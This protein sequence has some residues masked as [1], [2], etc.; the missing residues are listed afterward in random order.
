M[1]HHDAIRNAHH[2]VPQLTQHD[3][4]GE[5]PVCIDM[6]PNRHV[7]NLTIFNLFLTVSIAKIIGMNVLVTGS[8]GRLGAAIIRLLR[9]KNVKCY[10]CDVV[11]SETTDACV[12]ICDREKI[13]RIVNEVDSVIHTAAIH[14]KHMDMNTPRM[15]FVRTNINGTLNLLDAAVR[16]NV[17]NFIYT[18]TT[19][20]YG[21]LMD[22]ESEAVW[23][24]EDLPTK[25]RDIYDITKL[26]GEE[27]CR[28][29]FEKESLHT[30]ILRV[31]RFMHEPINTIANYRLYRGL[32]ERD[33]A[34]AH[35]LALNTK[36][37]FEVFNISNNSPFKRK[38]LRELKVAPES[39]ILKYYPESKEIYVRK[40]WTF[41]KSIDR[42][43]SIE[44]AKKLLGYNP[45]NNFIEF[46]RHA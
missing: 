38:D 7:R 45:K 37:T 31:S 26:A 13:F 42:V 34:E 11:P 3:G 2:D 20:V 28:D 12:D 41:P 30:C 39:V 21:K 16:S 24:Q 10:G 33:A 27:L 1:P 8:S 23:V 14:G 9:E 15:E 17:K 6:L 36:I 40:K 46:I 25:P 44:K 29:F 32:D 18:S 22:S 43:Y 5:V 4:V 19:S 35:W